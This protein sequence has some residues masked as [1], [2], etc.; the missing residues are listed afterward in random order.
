MTP[1]PL[2]TWGLESPVPMSSVLQRIANL[3]GQ[4][5]LRLSPDPCWMAALLSVG[6]AAPAASARASFSS[7]ATGESTLNHGI[8]PNATNAHY[9]Q[10]TKLCRHGCDSVW[11][12][13]FLQDGELTR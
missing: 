4:V 9:A 8:S 1:M 6:P 10:G 2:D 5:P 11:F 3:D 13:S 12:V 7:H